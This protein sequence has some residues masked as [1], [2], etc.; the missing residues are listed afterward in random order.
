MDG[1]GRRGAA[2]VARGTPPRQLSPPCRRLCRITHRNALVDAPQAAIARSRSNRLYW[3]ARPIPEPAEREGSGVFIASLYMLLFMLYYRN[4]RFLSSPTVPTPHAPPHALAFASLP[5]WAARSRSGPARSLVAEPRRGGLWPAVDC[6]SRSVGDPASDPGRPDSARTL[7]TGP[8]RGGDLKP[9]PAD[10]GGSPGRSA[11]QP[12]QPSD[13]AAQMVIAL[14]VPRRGLSVPP[15]P[16][17][18]WFRERPL[19]SRRL[20]GASRKPGGGG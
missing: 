9:A 16:W 3:C 2:G 8:G 18:G 4:S 11:R 19:W 17:P 13:G 5:P 6:Q 14:C 20:S 7:V 10:H 15:V 1:P 12:L